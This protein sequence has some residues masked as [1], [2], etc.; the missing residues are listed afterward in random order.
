MTMTTYSEA[1]NTGYEAAQ[2][3]E[4]QTANPYLRGTWEA[5]QWLLGWTD[6]E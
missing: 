1:Y 4:S 5:D 2:R 6:A 3:G